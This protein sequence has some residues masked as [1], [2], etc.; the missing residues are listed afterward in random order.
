MN[1]KYA[2]L[3]MSALM[4]TAGCIGEAGPVGEEGAQGPPGP[5]GPAGEEGAQGPPGEQGEVGPIGEEGAQGPPGEQGEP[6]QDVNMSYITQLE[7][8]IAANEATI[9]QLELALANA[10]SCQ[11]VPRGNCAGAWLY[12][13]NLSGM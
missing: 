8:D 3:I 11:L 12:G 5:Q 4:L 10:T 1:A 9:A 7:A 13:A 6:G 2:V